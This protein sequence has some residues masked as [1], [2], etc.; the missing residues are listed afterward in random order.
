[1]DVTYLQ[2]DPSMD[3][4]KS[5]SDN[6]LLDFH[7]PEYILVPGGKVEALSHAPAYPTIVFINPKSG[8]QLGGEL[9]VTYRS[10]LSQNQVFNLEE[11]APDDVLRRLYQTIEKLEVNGDQLAPLIQARLRIIVAGGD[12]TAAWLLGVVSDLQLSPAPPIATMSLGTGNNVPFAFGWGKRNPDTDKETV[13]QFLEQVKKAK[14]MEVDSWHIFLRTKSATEEGSCDPVPPLELPHSLHAFRRVSNT[15]EENTSGYDTYR[16]GFWNYFSM[17]MDAQISYAFHCERKLHPEKFTSQLAN[18]IQPVYTKL[19]S[20]Q[21]ILEMKEISRSMSD[22]INVILRELRKVQSEMSSMTNNLR[23]LKEDLRIM[24]NEEMED[25]EGDQSYGDDDED[26]EQLERETRG[27]R[28]IDH[29]PDGYSIS[30]PDSIPDPVP[31]S[32]PCPY[33]GSITNPDPFSCPI[34][35]LDPYPNS[36]SASKSETTLNSSS[37][38]NPGLNLNSNLKTQLVL[39]EKLMSSEAL[40]LNSKSQL[41]PDVY[42]NP[43]PNSDSKFNPISDPNFVFG[44]VMDMEIIGEKIGINN[45][46]PIAPFYGDGNEGMESISYGF[47]LHPNPDIDPDPPDVYLKP[48]H[49]SWP[50]TRSILFGAGKAMNEPAM[51]EVHSDGEGDDERKVEKEMKAKVAIDFEWNFLLN[52]QGEVRKYDEK[53]VVIVVEVVQILYSFYDN[54]DENA[55]RKAFGREEDVVGSKLLFL[56]I[57]QQESSREIFIIKPACDQIHMAMIQVRMESIVGLCKTMIMNEDQQVSFKLGEGDSGIQVETVQ[58]GQVSLKSIVG[59]TISQR[60]KLRGVEELMLSDS[61][62]QVAEVENPCHNCLEKIHQ[63]EAA[64]NVIVETENSFWFWVIGECE[65]KSNIEWLM[66]AITISLYISSGIKVEKD[67]KLIDS[68]KW[69]LEIEER[70]ELMRWKTLNSWNHKI[71]AAVLCELNSLSSMAI[72]GWQSTTLAKSW[73]VFG[74]IERKRQVSCRW[75]KWVTKGGWLEDAHQEPSPPPQPPPRLE[76]FDLK[77]VHMQGLVVLKDGLQHLYFILLQSEIMNIFF[78]I[79]YLLFFYKCYLDWMLIDSQYRNIAQLAKIKIMKRNGRWEDLQISPRYDLFTSF[80]VYYAGMRSI[81]CLNLPSFAGGLNP[82]GA[83]N[84]KKSRDVGTTLQSLSTCTYT[85][86][87]ISRDLRPPYVDDGLL[88]IVGFRNAWHGLALLAPNGHGTRLAQTNR[89]RIEF[90]KGEADCTYMRIDGEPWKQPLPVDENDTVMVEISHHERVTMLATEN[91][92]SKSVN[93]PCTPTTP[94]TP[95][96]QDSEEIDNSDD[97]DS[98]CD[99][100][101]PTEEERRKFGACESFRLTEDLD[102]DHLTKFGECESFRLPENL[103]VIQH[104]NTVGPGESFRFLE[105]LDIAHIS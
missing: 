57:P 92:V 96:N 78:Q 1:M 100:D 4:S 19:V 33:S 44:K 17:G 31:I 82:W 42:L 97:T 77:K 70:K 53:S 63:V 46:T 88:E 56:A 74:A 22:G 66:K 93:D 7:I 91:C 99:E 55:D 26:D 24:K 37:N 90:H 3:N 23:L 10:T 85:H 12:G 40:I 61:G 45:R 11:E 75:R 41:N 21:S 76:V 102:I 28:S 48:F 79:K 62:I 5:P 34:P 38:Q 43:N 67:W 29:Q 80:C 87:S 98:N 18:Q 84:R 103:D 83:P 47:S 71:A 68:T 35:N 13:M 69:A 20:E 51:E 39:R 49:N 27:D 58:G 72:G 36:Y 59:L 73:R 60:I 64:L 50:M 14:E 94:R 52:F 86:D 6:F 2:L 9:I 8:G 65:G 104:L 89:I 32:D 54:N 105:N 81:I 25:I 15:N 30:N 101:F 95:I 16:G